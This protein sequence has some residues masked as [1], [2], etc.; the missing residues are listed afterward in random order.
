MGHVMLGVLL[1]LLMIAKRFKYYVMCD[2]G[3][4]SI[5]GAVREPPSD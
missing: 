5:V 1:I 3:S 4:L 2:C